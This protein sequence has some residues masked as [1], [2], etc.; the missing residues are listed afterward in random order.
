[1]ATA[2]RRRISSGHTEMTLI[3]IA[4]AWRFNARIRWWVTVVGAS[5]LFSTV[6]LRYHYVVDV[7]GGVAFFLATMWTAPM[8]ERWW[9]R[10]VT[11][12]N[13]ALPP[14]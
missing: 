1:M 10:V 6:Y 13:A 12:A 4:L 11:H 8:I 5:L 3:T 14:H 7:A 2:Q 9:S